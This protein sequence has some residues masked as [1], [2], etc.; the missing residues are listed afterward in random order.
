MEFF[1]CCFKVTL[2]QARGYLWG[3][4]SNLLAGVREQIARNPLQGSEEVPGDMHHCPIRLRKDRFKDKIIK[5][6]HLSGAAGQRGKNILNG[7]VEGKNCIFM[8]KS[9]GSVLI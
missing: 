2:P 7:Q 9:F 6:D 4:C 8:K 1:L 5:I 3:E